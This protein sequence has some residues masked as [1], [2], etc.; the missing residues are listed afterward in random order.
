[1]VNILLKTHVKLLQT[2]MSIGTH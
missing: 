1:V 2:K